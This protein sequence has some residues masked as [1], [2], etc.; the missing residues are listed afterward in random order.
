MVKKDLKIFTYKIKRRKKACSREKRE[1][2]E[3][4]GFLTNNFKA[5]FNR[6]IAIIQLCWGQINYPGLHHLAYYINLPFF[7]HS[8]VNQK[9]LQVKEGQL[10][11]SIYIH[12]H[13]PETFHKL[14]AKWTYFC[15]LRFGVRKSYSHLFIKG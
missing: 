15:S 4:T 14:L 5:S 8:S 11:D 6:L 1:I 3:I 7:L 10:E 13:H 9:F 12:I 2:K